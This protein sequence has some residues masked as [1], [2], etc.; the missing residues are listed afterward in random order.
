MQLHDRVNSLLRIGE[1][2]VKEKN[3]GQAHY[4]PNRADGIHSIAYTKAAR[5]FC[6]R[7]GNKCKELGVR[8]ID[9]I[10]KSVLDAYM[11]RYES[12]RSNIREYDDVLTYIRLANFNIEYTKNGVVYVKLY[13]F[14]HIN[15]VYAYIRCETFGRETFEEQKKII[16]D[17]CRTYLVYPHIEWYVDVNCS[18]GTPT[19]SRTIYK[20]LHEEFCKNDSSILVV[21][22]LGIISKKP[23]QLFNEL[24]YLLENNVRIATADGFIDSISP[25]LIDVSAHSCAYTPMKIK[26]LVAE[27]LAENRKVYQ[28]PN[29][30][31]RKYYGN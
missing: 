20:Q 12:F 7:L 5:G 18:G 21:S 6:D 4:N 15:H 23:T 9:D 1:K 22:E 11:S 25:S 10:D 30:K 3:Q 27:I 29:E 28:H 31:E 8:S 13:R 26:S 16:E 24:Y 19:N 14:K 17:Y 2:K